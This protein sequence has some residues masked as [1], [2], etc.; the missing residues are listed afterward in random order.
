VVIKTGPSGIPNRIVQF[1]WVRPAHLQQAAHLANDFRL[2]HGE[3]QK[4]GIV[5][6]QIINRHLTSRLG[7]NAWAVGASTDDLPAMSTLGRVVQ[8]MGSAGNALPLRMVRTC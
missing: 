6:S 3:V 2:H 4:T 7:H 8:T 1:P 5:V